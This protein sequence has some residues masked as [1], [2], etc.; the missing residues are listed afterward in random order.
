MAEKFLNCSAINGNFIE[1]SF[2]WGKV[3]RVIEK[4]GGKSFHDFLG[5]LDWNLFRNCRCWIISWKIIL[6]S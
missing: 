4:I 2:F 1:K 5:N 3:F 6:F